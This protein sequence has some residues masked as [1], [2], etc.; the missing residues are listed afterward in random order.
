MLRKFLLLI[1]FVYWGNIL[2]AQDNS[3]SPFLDIKCFP[4]L[5]KQGI[6]RQTWHLDSLS[7]I[8]EKECQGV[9][10]DLLEDTLVLIPKERLYAKD[11]LFVGIKAFLQSDSSAI[12]HLYAE[13]VL[14]G[15]SSGRLKKTIQYP[16]KPI[17]FLIVLKSSNSKLRI[18]LLS[19]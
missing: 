18:S 6:I 2:R 19:P 15:K 16:P 17:S 9:I 12:A 10:L 1:I 5:M 8:L 3:D 4:E 11:S 13:E 7:Q 14:K